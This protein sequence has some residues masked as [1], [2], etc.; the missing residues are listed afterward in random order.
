VCIVVGIDVTGDGVC[1]DGGDGNGGNGGNGGDGD[2]KFLGGGK[3]SESDGG[4]DEV[5]D[6]GI[7]CGSDLC[8]PV[9]TDENVVTLEIPV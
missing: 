7:L 3:S 2:C 9:F 6:A 1:G 5:C 4:I 8:S